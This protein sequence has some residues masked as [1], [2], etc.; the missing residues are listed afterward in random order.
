MSSRAAAIDCPPPDQLVAFLGG[1]LT[2]DRAITLES[3][4]DECGECRAVMSNM[5]RGGPP[6]ALGRYRIDTVLGSGGMGIVYRGFDPQL[7]RPVAIKVVRRAGDDSAG[8]ARLV[9]EAQALARLSHPN[10]CHVYDVGTQDE[11]V[12][13]AME[14]IDGVQLRQW[15]SEGR[16]REEIVD[17]LLGAADGIAAA[18]NVGLVHRDI[19][20]ENV[21]VTRDGRPIVT[22]FGL[23]RHEDAIDV[24]APTVASDPQLTA[25]GAIAGTPAY[26]APEQLLGDPIDARVDQFAWAVMAWELLTN[27]RPFPIVF[28]VRVEAV[29]AGVAQPANMPKHLFDAL[30]RAMSATPS[31]RFPSMRELIAAVRAAPATQALATPIVPA[32]GRTAAI[33]GLVVL[34]ASGAALLAWKKSP[35]PRPAPATAPAVPVAESPALTPAPL[36]EVTSPAPAPALEPQPAPPPTAPAVAIAADTAPAPIRAKT[37]PKPVRT[38]VAIAAPAPTP[39]PGPAPTTPQITQTEPQP[40]I[41]AT[42]APAPS[43]GRYCRSCQIASADAFCRIPTDFAHTGYPRNFGVVDW[44]VVTKVENESG[45]FRDETIH[46]TVITLRG[47]RKTYRFTADF[48]D[49]YVDTKVGAHIAICPEDQSDLYRLAGGPTDLT[50]AVITMSGPP[51][52]LV[53]AKL[54]AKHTSDISLAATS[55]RKRFDDRITADGTYLVHAKIH[56]VDGPRYRMDRYWMQ[57]PKGMK[58]E[59]KLETNKLYWFV[60]EKGTFVEIEGKEQLLVKAAAILDDIFPN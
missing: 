3:H 26:L 47:Q 18:H 35:E 44:G 59:D 10:V 56:G 53:A 52:T 5:A 32:R 25:T 28:A 17:A 7:A 50:R 54:G 2:E 36:H 15:A 24:N 30:A 48:L 14:L 33:A 41:I 8:R 58:N 45:T 37:P 60:V 9:R 16:T 13:V 39:A 6:P 1:E 23:A 22:D 4:M 55:L 19:K 46:E 27:S 57:V 38:E 43:R 51:K 42:P 29:R 11:E 40:P 49:S 20:P 12:W 31:D 21:L 34:G